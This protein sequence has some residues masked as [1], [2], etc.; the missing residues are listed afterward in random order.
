MGWWIHGDDGDDGRGWRVVT[1]GDAALFPS[2]LPDKLLGRALGGAESKHAP[3]KLFYAGSM[4][5]P[6]P[7]PRVSVIGSRDASDEGIEEARNL[8][9]YLASRDVVVVSG[10]ARGIDTAVHRAA[11]ESGGKTIAVLGTPLDRSSPKK[12]TELQKEIMKN[13]LAISQYPVDHITLPRDFANR[14][15]TMALISD[16]TV[17]V[18]A[19]DASG[20][21]RHAEESLRLG[22]PLFVCKAMHDDDGLEWPADVA[23]SGA[24]VLTDYSDVVE[25]VRSA[26][27]ERPGSL[28]RT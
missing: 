13:H 25:C 7:G 22:R 8:A 21:L 27:F 24:M 23:K 11:I 2:V 4:G 26:A 3:K 16:A 5:I 15:N 28:F 1:D 18:E 10:L 12:N 19:R 6:V 17:V 9:R 14:N 20:S